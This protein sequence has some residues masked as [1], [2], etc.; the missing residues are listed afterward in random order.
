MVYH[1]K[2][3]YNCFIPWHIEEKKQWLT[4]SMRHM[5]TLAVFVIG[6]NF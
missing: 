3:L 6:G 2:V 4:P 5:G 1:E